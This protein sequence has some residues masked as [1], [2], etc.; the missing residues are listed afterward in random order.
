MQIKNRV[1]DGRAH[2][3]DCHPE[4]PQ[5]FGRALSNP[6]AMAGVNERMNGG[7]F[8]I[9]RW[10]RGALVTLDL[11]YNFTVRFDMDT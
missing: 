10:A 7:L 6:N 11:A 4:P 2:S 8:P 5:D 3:L 1:S 9:I